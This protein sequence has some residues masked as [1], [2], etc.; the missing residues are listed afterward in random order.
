ML[1]DSHPYTAIYQQAHDI[2]RVSHFI[3]HTI[4]LYSDQFCL[5]RLNH[6]SNILILESTFFCS[7]AMIKDIIIFLLWIKLL[8][9]FLIKTFSRLELSMTL[10]FIFK[11]VAYVTL[12][13]YILPTLLFTICFFFHMVKMAGM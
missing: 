7:K 1:K 12:A 8:L 2:M 10:L 5:Y 6:L 11:V 13:T 3:I 4:S 9:L